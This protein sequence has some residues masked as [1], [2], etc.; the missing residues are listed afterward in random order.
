MERILQTDFLGD[1]TLGLFGFAT[2]KYCVLGPKMNFKKIEDVLHVKAHEAKLFGTDLSGLFAAGNSRGIAVAST[3]EKHEKEALEK[4]TKV[5]LLKTDFTALGNLILMNDRGCVISRMIKN[6]KEEIEKFF[7]IPCEISVSRIHVLGSAALPSNTGCAVH[8]NLE[9]ESVRQ[10]SDVLGV[11][12]EAAT[13]NFGSPFVGACAI[14][15]SHG[16][17]V[18]DQST[19]IEISRLEEILFNKD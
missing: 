7:K 19:G 17:V 6:Q 1:P 12:C 10:I 14:S 15:N 8:P 4:I 2:D 13:A 11:K 9:E 3:I 18:S 16:L 5:L